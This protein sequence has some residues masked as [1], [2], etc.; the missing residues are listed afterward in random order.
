MKL[1]K[2]WSDI[3]EQEFKKQYFKDIKN[4]LKEE[5]KS[6]KIIY[7]ESKK[8]FNAL[9]SVKFKKVKVVILWQDPY[10]WEWQAHGLS[11]SVQEWVKVPPS[12]R[13]I[14]K[15]IKNDLWIIKDNNYWN[16]NEWTKE[17]ILLLNSI[18]TVEAWKPA[19]HSKIWWD[20]FTDNIIKTLSDKRK[21][22]VFILWWAFAQS[23]INLI[24]NSKH[25][26][27]KAPHPSPFSAYKWFFW[28]KHFSKTNDYLI[29][30]NIKQINW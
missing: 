7:P 27:L 24:D 14:Y 28:C 19:S 23:K 13:N 17:W 10:H 25:L 12:L 18:L 21:N 4:F 9:N 30:N 11:F 22:L 1:N 2:N 26:I 20:I 8:I 6:W 3:L 16:L 29:K 15:E 5:K